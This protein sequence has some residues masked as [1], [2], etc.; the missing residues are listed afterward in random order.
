[1]TFSNFAMR[2]ERHQHPYGMKWFIFDWNRIT[3]TCIMCSMFSVRRIRTT[4]FISAHPNSTTFLKVKHFENWISWSFCEQESSR[5]V[6]IPFLFCLSIAHALKYLKQWNS[7]VCT[8]VDRNAI[9][10]RHFHS[11]NILQANEKHLS[12]PVQRMDLQLHPFFLFLW[13]HS[14]QFPS[15]RYA[16]SWQSMRCSQR[17][18]SL[19][20][21]NGMF[22]VNLSSFFM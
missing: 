16:F 5:S 12:I 7:V 10:F 11:S 4:K 13:R 3:L 15:L 8:P 20:L 1:M 2:F 19:W 17:I 18:F 22:S 14:T 6:T 9:V 21:E